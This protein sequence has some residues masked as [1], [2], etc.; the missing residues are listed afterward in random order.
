MIH[1]VNRDVRNPLPCTHTDGFQT[2][3]H[4]E[5]VVS[6]GQFAPCTHPAPTRWVCNLTRPQEAFF[7]IPCERALGP[8]SDLD[9]CIDVPCSI[10]ELRDGQ[11]SL[12]R[13]GIGIREILVMEHL[14]VGRSTKVQ[15]WSVPEGTNLRSINFQQTSDFMFEWLP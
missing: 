10:S 7:A 9:H 14:D 11:N 4:R 13:Q 3:R 2:D 8:F 6:D 1:C 12:L 15:F 5:L